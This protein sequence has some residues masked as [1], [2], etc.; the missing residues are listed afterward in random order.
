MRVGLLCCVAMLICLCSAAAH[1]QAT[2]TPLGDLPGGIFSR[3]L[4]RPC[5]LTDQWWSAI[6]GLWMAIEAISLD[7]QRQA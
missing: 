7:S 2:F 5:R 6:V 3:T 1:A 4:A